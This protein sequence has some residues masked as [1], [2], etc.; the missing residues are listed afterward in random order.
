MALI[1]CP[2]CKGDVSDTAYNCPKC[3]YSISQLINCPECE[4]KISKKNPECPH[5]GYPFKSNIPPNESSVIKT[6]SAHSPPH[7]NSKEKPQRQSQFLLVR[8][9]NKILFL[10]FLII[11]GV[12][13]Y[14]LIFPDDNIISQGIAKINEA[15]RQ[16]IKGT[17]KINEDER[18]KLI[19][20]I[21]SYEK[22]TIGKVRKKEA[23]DARYRREYAKKSREAC[24]SKAR[25]RYNTCKRRRDSNPG[26][27]GIADEAWA[28]MREAQRQEDSCRYN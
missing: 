18:Q 28:C 20:S 24:V 6:G 21:K 15:A 12:G 8:T 7:V 19:R 13:T 16:K 5:C 23:E 9:F 11:I 25:S 27:M 2:G 26:H 17:A 10:V 3:G 4:K 14:F 1:E 22:T